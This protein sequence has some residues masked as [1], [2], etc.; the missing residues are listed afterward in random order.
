MVNN[1][2]Q[3]MAPRWIRAAVAKNSRLS[4]FGASSVLNGRGRKSQQKKHVYTVYTSIYGTIL[5]RTLRNMM[6]H[7][8]FWDR[9]DVYPLIAVENMKNH[10]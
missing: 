9:W 7:H 5:M 6:I 3:Y 1:P 2:L 4:G 8:E 10:P